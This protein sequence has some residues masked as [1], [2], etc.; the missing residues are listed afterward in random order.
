[1]ALVAAA[2]DDDELASKNFVCFFV[3]GLTLFDRK[4]EDRKMGR[5]ETDMCSF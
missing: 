5:G 4:M 2:S 1:V 3:S